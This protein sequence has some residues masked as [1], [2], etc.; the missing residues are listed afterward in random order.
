VPAPQEAAAFLRRELGA[1]MLRLKMSFYGKDSTPLVMGQSYFDDQ[2][3][4]LS[5]VQAW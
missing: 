2:V 1:A 3:L 4:H 5:L